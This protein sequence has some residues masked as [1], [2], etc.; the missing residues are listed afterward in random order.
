MLQGRPFLTI[1]L[2]FSFITVFAQR[3]DG[4]RYIR[5]AEEFSVNFEKDT[6]YRQQVMPFNKIIV[7][8]KRFDS[9]KVGYTTAGFLQNY[10]KI[11]L[12]RS[13]SDITTHYFKK[14]LDSTSNKSLVIVL[15]SYWLQKGAINHIVQKKIVKTNVSGTEYGGSCIADMD[16]Y[17]QTDSTLQALFRIDD[18]FLDLKSNYQKSTIQYFF[19][20]PFDSIARRMATISVP[21]ILAKKRKITWKE[22]NDHYDERFKLPVLADSIKRGV[23]RTFD[24]FK[25]NKPAI[26][27]FKFVNERVVDNLYHGDKGTGELITDYWG[28]F[29]GRDLYIQAGLS[30][31]KAV[32]QQDTF[33]LFG[34][35]VI[36]NYHNSPGLNEI[37]VI[38]YDV[39]RKIL[40]VNMDTGKIY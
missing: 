9:S 11:V 23:Y 22:V 1:I 27:S 20:L 35:K 10:S 24:D 30:A 3:N 38:G 40:Q 6:Y 14:H 12:T 33:E 25:Q 8:D 7:V 13:W 31:F 37:R 32:R 2:L 34:S 39:D 4:T 15:K 17:V 29:D 16:I 19:F 36:N 18:V 21:E 5:N 28:F 26:T